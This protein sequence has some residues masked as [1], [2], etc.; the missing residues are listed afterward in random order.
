MMWWIARAFGKPFEL[1]NISSF[2]LLA[3]R[4][5]P[6]TS[7]VFTEVLPS[8]AAFLF[9][10]Q[11]AN[12]VV[13]LFSMGLC[14]MNSGVQR[15][16]SERTQFCPARPA[17]LRSGARIG[18]THNFVDRPSSFSPGACSAG[19]REGED[20]SHSSTPD[21]GRLVSSFESAK[22]TCLGAWG[23]PEVRHDHAAPLLAGRKAYSVLET[24]RRRRRAAH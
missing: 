22:D 1:P 4:L 2:F 20:Q 24:L 6:P 5:C 17:A 8:V 14:S 11:F 15:S 23:V 13:Y 19:S 3:Q 9:H 10:F 18:P 21:N 16:T 7:R 12:S